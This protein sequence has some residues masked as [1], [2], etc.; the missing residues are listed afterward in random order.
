V[1]C[2]C[3]VCVCVCVWPKLTSMRS[4]CDVLYCHFGLPH[5]T[6]FFHSIPQTARFSEK[7]I[8]GTKCVF[9][10]PLQL[11]S[12]AFL[13]LRTVRRYII[14]CTCYSHHI[15]V[16][17]CIFG[18]FSKNKYQISW[19]SFHWEPGVVLF[20]AS[21]RKN[22]QTDRRDAADSRFSLFCKMCLITWTPF[23]S[24]H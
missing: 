9:W 10:F 6:V 7:K 20:H 13:I 14:T 16:K 17:I 8:L 4:T 24:F 22:R 21:R 2:V 12:E 11:L 23:C 18:W 1:W 19:K 5:S 15:L 3:G